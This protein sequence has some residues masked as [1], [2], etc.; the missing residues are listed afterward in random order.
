MVASPILEV[1]KELLLEAEDESAT[2]AAAV[3][4]P[5]PA[6]P[7]QFDATGALLKNLSYKAGLLNIG[8]GAR[9]VAKH[10]LSA[11]AKRPA[12]AQGTS[13]TVLAFTSSQVNVKWEMD[14]AQ[15][16]GVA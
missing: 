8:V 9:V 10:D 14:P 15:Q 12:I 2:G 7:V 16:I 3:A 5:N 1:T 6:A 13:G 11:T 4:S